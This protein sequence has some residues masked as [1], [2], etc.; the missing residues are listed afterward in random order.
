[1]VFL[2]FARK[3]Q[4]GAGDFSGVSAVGVKF[5][6][7]RGVL[8]GEGESSPTGNALS[9]DRLDGDSTLACGGLGC[10]AFFDLILKYTS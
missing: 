2:V 3:I 5:R 10:V 8:A 1:M 4:A 6:L 7:R 9:V